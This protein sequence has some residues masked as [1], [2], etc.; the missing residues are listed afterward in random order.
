MGQF[1]D[2]ICFCFFTNGINNAVNVFIMAVCIIFEALKGLVLDCNVKNC[3]KEI[4]K[5][6]FDMKL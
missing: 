2:S 4:L 1:N 3:L 5:F 6:I